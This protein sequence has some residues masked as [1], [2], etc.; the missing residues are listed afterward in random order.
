[1][2]F[3]YGHHHHHGE[4]PDDRHSLLNASCLYALDKAYDTVFDHPDFKY[5]VEL[6][7]YIRNE[8]ETLDTT[9]SGMKHVLKRMFGVN[10]EITLTD[11]CGQP[12][13]FGCN[14]YPPE[15]D[16]RMIASRIVNDHDINVDK[17]RHIWNNIN[18]W[19]LDLDSRMFF[20]TSINLNPGEIAVIIFFNIENVVYNLRIV[21]RTNRV[22]N[23]MFVNKGLLLN[24]LARTSIGSHVF[25]LPLINAC[26]FKSYPFE[27]G[28]FIDGSFFNLRPELCDVYNNAI[29]KIIISTSAQDIDVPLTKMDEDISGVAEWLFA[30][31]ADMQ[32][33]TRMIQDV[34]KKLLLI[35]RSNYMKTILSNIL[36][37]IGDYSRE[38]VTYLESTIPRLR[39]Q[40]AL[41]PNAV[42]MRQKQ[43][44]MKA[45]KR[46]KADCER[47]VMEGFLDLLDNIGNMKKVSQ[48]EIDMVRVQVQKVD[49]V[50]D[51]LY[52][53]DELHSKL[54]IVE[55]SLTLLESGD[56]D[57]IKKVKLSKSVLLDQ[58]KQLDAIRN[59][60]IKREIKDPEYSLTVKYPKGYEG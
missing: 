25:I 6:L 60:I 43:Y 52:L 31:I 11:N 46:I 47:V 55:T 39:E 59:E 50:D 2:D 4:C 42:A 21:E 41:N 10:F 19:Q 33:S 8:K 17:L 34:I 24:N 23:Q 56:K 18:T 49:S 13:F 38:Q 58:K 1:M 30:A 36:M 53:L 7:Q 28:K 48:K 14:V 37:G 26:M 22:L 51:K 44:Y 12:K 35:E 57:K 45:Q 15:D 54:D 20:D 40:F 3:M 27:E 16:A 29:K 9:I 32:F 5:F